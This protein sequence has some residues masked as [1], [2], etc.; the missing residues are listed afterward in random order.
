MEEIWC[1]KTTLSCGEVQQICT[2]SF[3]KYRKPT[4]SIWY[5]GCLQIVEIAALDQQFTSMMLFPPSAS[6]CWGIMDFRGVL[7]YRLAGF[8][9][10]QC[11]H[12]YLSDKLSQ[13]CSLLGMDNKSVQSHSL[14]PWHLRKCHALD[15]RV[16]RRSQRIVV[17][18]LQS[19]KVS[20]IVHATNWCCCTGGSGFF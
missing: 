9:C 6:I 18:P 14:L 3:V 15:V 2:Y 8:R 10:E 4:C 11:L 1:P 12:Q 7:P 17:T 13:P 5:S 20:F 16:V 19:T